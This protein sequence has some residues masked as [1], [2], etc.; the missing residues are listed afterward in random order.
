MKSRLY[1]AKRTRTFKPKKNSN[2]TKVNID[3]I[4]IKQPNIKVDPLKIR[5]TTRNMV[6]RANNILLNLENKIAII[7]APTGSGK[8][9]SVIDEVK[10]RFGNALL[11]RKI[12]LA[13]P[14]RANVFNLGGLAGDLEVDFGMHIGG[15]DG[16]MRELSNY[17]TIYTYGKLFEKLKHD[18]LLSEYEELILD[19]ADVITSGQEI[20]WIPVLK[21]LKKVRP[22]LKII[23]MSATLDIEGF[24]KLFEIDDKAIFTDLTNS[25]PRPIQK[26][27]V[28]DMEVKSR[29]LYVPRSAINYINF[30]IDAVT[31]N[32]FGKNALIPT[33]AILVFMPTIGSVERLSAILANKYKDELEIRTLHSKKTKE[34]LEKD[35]STPIERNKI[36]VLIATDIIGRGINFNDDLR[37]NRVIH[38]GLSNRRNYNEVTRKDLLGVGVSSLFDVTQA[39]GRAGRSIKDDRPVVGLCLQPISKLK[40]GIDSSLNNND[41]TYMI[42]QCSKVLKRI[43]SLKSNV[44]KPASLLEFLSPVVVD[45]TRIQ[46]SIDKLQALDALDEHEMITSFGSFLID[47]GLDL[48]FGL[49]L[50]SSL[51][52]SYWPQ[53][54]DVL[55]MANKGSSLVN[56]ELKD[57]YNA[58]INRL[59]KTYGVKSDLDVYYYLAQ[60]IE[61]R[62]DAENSGINYDVFEEAKF[63]SKTL[64]KKVNEYISN[65]SLD[66]DNLNDKIDFE[67]LAMES[68]SDCLFEFYKMNHTK[69]RSAAEYIHLASKNIF[70]LSGFSIL[71]INKPPRYLIASNMAIVN[72]ELTITEG[73]PVSEEVLLPNGFNIEEELVTINK[74]DPRTGEG[75]AHINRVYKG[76]TEKTVLNAYDVKFDNDTF[77]IQA[78]AKHLV[79]ESKLDWVKKNQEV[80]NRINYFNP[81]LLAKDFIYKFYINELT[82][83]DIT[84]TSTLKNLPIDIKKILK[85]EDYKL[86]RT[87]VPNTIEGL[88]IGFIT[89]NKGKIAPYVHLTYSQ[90][91]NSDIINALTKVYKKNIL[92]STQIGSKTVFKPVIE[93][94]KDIQHTYKKQLL[95]KALEVNEQQDFG[96][97]KNLEEV[98]VLPEPLEYMSG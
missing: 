32:I 63:A 44:Y 26:L 76:Y 20:R 97:I 69:N 85:D 43:Q 66:Y 42:L 40:K 21:W 46:Q 53:L 17:G 47:I 90:L 16:D 83:H 15:E 31:M 37:I 18:P 57:I 77:A 2:P 45:K 25:R 54:V 80:V 78:L 86:I 67:F 7:Q 58:Y 81:K 89:L 56:F 6:E 95:K 9:H 14:T 50:Y 39:F 49:M 51:N 5:E 88:E 65:S 70:T 55:A 59:A 27:F 29:D 33:E 11:N 98:P 22:E 79:I 12:A 92:T 3:T 91:S 24:K 30:A 4:E 23:L 62:E 87:E 13:L 93:A 41:P 94:S 35:I 36:G 48:D 28:T 64:K 75:K 72:G 60:T 84:N 61:N 10:N 8:T 71:N 82:F 52:T 74:F 38:S 68:L 1:R 73:I 96:D 19:E 34:E